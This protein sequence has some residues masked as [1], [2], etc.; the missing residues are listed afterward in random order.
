MSMRQVM[1]TLEFIYEIYAPLPGFEG[2]ISLFLF[3]QGLKI[4]KKNIQK[5]SRKPRTP[6]PP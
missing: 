1:S 4:Q 6:Q 3:A 2:D 5:I